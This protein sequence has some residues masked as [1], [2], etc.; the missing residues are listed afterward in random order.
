M[1]E[2]SHAEKMYNKGLK[3]TRVQMVLSILIDARIKNDNF[4]INEN[5][6]HYISGGYR[7]LWALRGQFKGGDSAGRRLRELRSHI[8]IEKKSH[9]YGNKTIVIY[10]LNLTLDEVLW[11]PWG[12]AFTL[13]FNWTYKEIKGQLELL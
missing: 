7:P 2:L 8:P 13:P 5:P 11:Y 4:R 10:R 12:E 1:S 6:R 3:P 9:K